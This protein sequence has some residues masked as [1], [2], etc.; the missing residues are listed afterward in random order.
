M[1]MS[2]KEKRDKP[3][4]IMVPR[5]FINAIVAAFL[6]L[7]VANLASFQYA[8]YIDRKSN[9]LLCGIVTLSVNA[10]KLNPAPSETQR[11]AAE[12]FVKIQEGYNCK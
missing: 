1:N 12:E 9:K 8:N 10:A 4:Y 3:T 11:I 2:D 7:A 6:G 5:K